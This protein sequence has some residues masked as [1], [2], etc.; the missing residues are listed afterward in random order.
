MN[1]CCKKFATVT[2][3]I[4]G[5]VNECIK[6]IIYDLVRNYYTVLASS[7]IVTTI[8]AFIICKISHGNTINF[9]HDDTLTI[10]IFSLM[11]TKT[12]NLM[13]IMLGEYLNPWCS[14]WYGVLL[15]YIPLT[16]IVYFSN[17][18]IFMK[19]ICHPEYNYMKWKH[20][21]SNIFAALF[22]YAIYLTIN[23]KTDLRNSDNILLNMCSVFTG[24]IM[25]SGLIVLIICTIY[26]LISDALNSCC[27]SE[28]I[29]AQ[30]EVDR[31]SPISIEIGE[32]N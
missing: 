22:L 2:L 11:L 3:I 28:R 15:T 18:V 7:Y 30:E 25:T 10:F 16:F 12:S 31:M 6:Y 5:F 1:E 13:L 26:A 19:G 14:V 23:Y 8:I 20:I 32:E 17:Y 21:F 27:R 4:L 9:T 24:V 29:L